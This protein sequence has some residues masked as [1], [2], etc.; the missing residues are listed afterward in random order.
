[1]LFDDIDIKE[2]NIPVEEVK[3]ILQLMLILL[4]LHKLRKKLF[5]L[6]PKNATFLN[7]YMILRMILKL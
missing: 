5:I 7:I 2:N 3:K 1:M 6:L 4:L